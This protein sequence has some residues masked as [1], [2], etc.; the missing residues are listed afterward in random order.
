MK[1]LF[2]Y[3]W[4]WIKL[5]TEIDAEDLK[6]Y[7]SSVWQSRKHLFEQED[8]EETEEDISDIKRYK[9]GFLRFDGNYISAKNYVGFIQYNGTGINILPKVF[10]NSYPDPAEHTKK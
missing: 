3:E 4:K 1:Q 9:Q 5:P 2:L 7:L 8:T 6:R 10:A